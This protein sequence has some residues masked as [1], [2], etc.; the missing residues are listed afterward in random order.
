M[1]PGREQ[2]LS[3]KVSALMVASRLFESDFCM[4]V[5]AE[6]LCGRSA[7]KV[8]AAS[9]APGVSVNEAAGVLNQR[10][11]V[12]SAYHDHL[13]QLLQMEEGGARYV[14]VET[15]SVCVG[16]PFAPTKKKWKPAAAP[17]LP[18]LTC[19]KKNLSG[20]WYKPVF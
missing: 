19:K 9:V 2:F 18:C 12:V 16:C 11:R 1:L 15:G 20:I 3:E 7:P 10:I 13:R 4:F 14:L 5:A 6:L 8:T 17:V